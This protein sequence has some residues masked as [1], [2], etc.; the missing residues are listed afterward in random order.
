MHYH[1][2]HIH[3]RQKPG[4][5]VRDVPDR[6]QRKQLHGGQ[7]DIRERG[8]RW[9]YG[10]NAEAFRPWPQPLQPPQRQIDTGEYQKRD[11]TGESDQGYKRQRNG[12]AEHNSTAEDGSKD[13][14]AQPCVDGA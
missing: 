13:R 3:P 11:G 6:L 2:L 1:A 7:A 4:A 14:G 5:D 8:E 10:R 9:H 12:E